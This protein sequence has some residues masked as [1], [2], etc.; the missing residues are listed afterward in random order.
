MNAS[1]APAIPPRRPPEVDRARRR[2]REAARHAR[3][4]QQA[5][6]RDVAL[7]AIAALFGLIAGP[8]LGILTLL[9]LLVLAGCA[10]WA[11]AERRAASQPV[12]RRRARTRG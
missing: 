12:R 11:L 4:R 7:G 9:A 6:R 2:R 5:A 1:P 8:G 10:A 3:R